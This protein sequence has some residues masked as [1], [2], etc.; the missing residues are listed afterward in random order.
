MKGPKDSGWLNQ[1]EW[2]DAHPGD[3]TILP[4]HARV[5]SIVSDRDFSVGPEM[6][7]CLCIGRVASTTASGLTLLKV[8][9]LTP[10]GVGYKRLNLGG[11]RKEAPR[12]SYRTWI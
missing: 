1:I 2:S 4:A 5:E 12:K 7:Y 10:T 11:D 3:F 6:V 8:Y 9:L